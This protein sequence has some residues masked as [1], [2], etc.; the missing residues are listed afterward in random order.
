MLPLVQMHPMVPPSAH[1]APSHVKPDLYPFQ[2]HHHHTSRSSTLH[3][4]ASSHQ[5]R[6]FS[7]RASQ[8]QSAH[9]RSSAFHHHDNHEHHLRR[10][11][12]NGTIDAGYDGTPAQLASGPP[13]LKHMILPAAG[14]A[15]L[16]REYNTASS[17]RSP[18]TIN[19]AE[20]RGFDG[21]DMNLLPYAR[22]WQYGI[23]GVSRNT[24]MAMDCAPN[25]PSTVYYPYNNGVRVPT[26]L[27]PTYHQSPGPPVFNNGGLLPPPAWPDAN[28][29]GYHHATLGGPSY[30]ALNRNSMLLNRPSDPI[31]PSTPPLGLG[32]GYDTIQGIL[33]I[34]AQR[35]ESLSL[36]QNHYNAPSAQL[37]ETASPVRFRERALANAHRTYV[38]LLAYLHQSKKSQPGRSSAG[39][40]SSSKMMIFPKLPKP[41]H[42]SVAAPDRRH[43]KNLR[44]HTH[45]VD[46][47]H[48]GATSY[49][50]V[51][52]YGSSDTFLQMRSSSHQMSAGG[53]VANTSYYHLLNNEGSRYGK[54][55]H[56]LLTKSPLS[57]AK[58]AVEMLN[59]LCEQSGW[60]WIDGMLL[61]GCLYYG[62]ERYEQALEWFTRIV[63][64]DDSHIEALSNVAA[65]LYCLHRNEEAE[66]HWLQAVQR[67]PS[68][69]EAVEHLVGLLCSTQRSKEAV[70][71]ITYVQRSL[72]L[73]DQRTAGEWDKE[74]GGERM[75]QSHI[76]LEMAD[77]GNFMEA[78]SHDAEIPSQAGFGS[79]GYRIPASENGRIIA[80]IHAK[81]NMLYALKDIERASE[82]FEEA[83]LISAGRRL[84]CIQSLIRRI[85]SVLSTPE[86]QRRASRPSLQESLSGPLLLPPE[87]ARHTAQLVFATR[88][89]L[90]GLRQ[91][92]DGVPRRSAV[93]TTS[94]SLLSLAKIFQDG[95]SNGGSSTGLMRRPSG[96]GDILALYYLSLSLSES[97]STANNVGI[98]LASVPQSTPTQ[99]V[100]MAESSSNP[101]IPGIVPGSGLDLALA[102]YKYGLQLDSKHVHLHTNLG[103]LL[104]DIGQLDLAISM[105]EQAVACD[106]TFDI[107]L[108]NL[109]NAVK[110]RGRISEAIMYYK[111]AVVAN[112]HFAEA[113]CGL[114]TALNSVC[115]WRER[116]GVVLHSGKYDRWHVNDKGMLQ[117]GRA[118]ATGFGLVSRVVDIV[119]RQLADSSQWGTGVL[120]SGALEVLVHQFRAAGANRTDQGLNL[121]VELRRWAG[122]SW[123][124]SRVLRLVERSI[125]AAMRQWYQDNYVHG[126]SARGG[127]PRPRLPV[128][129]TVPSA[130]TVLPF[131]T[132]TCPLTAKDIRMISQRN[133][134]RI[135]CSTLRSPWLPDSVYPPPPPPKPHLNIGYVSSDFNNHPLAHLMQ[136]VFGL[137]NPS[138]AKAF[139]YATTASDKSIHRHQIEREAPVFRDVSSWSAER[140]VDQI[141]QD[142]IHILVNLNG[143]TRGARNEI[144]AARPAPIQ[145]SFMGFAGTLGAEWCDYILADE[146]AIPPSTLRPSRKNVSLED[147]FRDEEAVEDEDWMYA[148]NIIFCRDTFFCCDHA[149]SS[150]PAERMVTWHEEQSRRWKMRKELFPHLPDDTIILGNFNQLYKIDPSTFRTWLRILSN[151]PK[152]VLWLLRFPELGESNLKRTAKLWASEEVASRIIFTDVAPKQQHISR[153]RV[154]DLFL[155]T[156]ECNAHTTAADVLWSS[157]PLLTLPRYPY[158]MCSRM[159]ASI[160]KG[161]LPKNARGQDMARELIATDEDDYEAMATKLASSLN[162]RFT[163]G[164]YGEGRGRLAEMR[165]VLFDAKWTCALF[166]T[167][168]WVRD[169]EDAYEEAWRK[170]VAGDSGDIYL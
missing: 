130:P 9:P 125:K 23:D 18:S 67:K 27:Q 95:M 24:A 66:K 99:P 29:P 150:E 86:M 155:D 59:H 76:P 93:S 108:T 65:T 83:V 82:A 41:P 47:I 140:L 20:P 119:S 68:Y 146:T 120:H 2:Q 128:T 116:G 5:D 10:K 1:L 154:C 19:P 164:Q 102:Y 109:A 153:A 50:G 115:D 149:Q 52:R 105:Y 124:G 165:K 57:N 53:P 147:V 6:P 64:L 145:M 30:Y 166:D 49:T 137:H 141:I 122:R 22:G 36:E 40:R 104:K 69:L 117:D 132:F 167:R 55:A 79:S 61:G 48:P 54:V 126:Q 96:V 131:H 51:N 80:L 42:G 121:E 70:D 158:K 62:L 60:R 100:L 152:A 168:R 85:Q 3:G 72:R 17:Y 35:L 77:M 110:D 81:G 142:K 118:Q 138:R 32:A 73:H 78:V 133:A 94:N 28:L 12:P 129:L 31:M 144:F 143:Y 56:P 160:L 34:P 87:K 14:N 156:P 44:D 33:Q 7:T 139:C 45:S 151:V 38:E 123:E 162:Y 134:L 89:E 159:A 25:T 91:V 46:G 88:G 148:E 113:V 37:P 103:S 21:S 16:A 26:A 39:S 135:S 63:T 90:P 11:T 170:W 75:G 13:P 169:L 107:A 127:Y 114:S 101:P 136:S 112:P 97:P 4:L 106:G 71:I 84:G 74:S 157:T 8:L 163:N 161:A 92:P 43:S 58:T 98:L 111:R 15:Q